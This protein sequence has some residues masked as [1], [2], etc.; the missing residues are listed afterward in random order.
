MNH[1]L[2]QNHIPDLKRVELPE[3]ITTEQVRFALNTLQGHGPQHAYRL[4]IGDARAA[5]H[6]PRQLSRK[7]DKAKNNAIVQRYMRALVAELERVAVANALDLK[8]FLS[9]VV[10]TP[11]GAI[12]ENHVLCQKK[13]T[14]TTTSKAG[15]ETTRQLVEMPSKKD[16]AALLIR[17]QGLD[18]PIRVDHNHR[19]GVMV[20]PMA[21]NVGDWERIA[22]ASQLKLMEDAIEI[23]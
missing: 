6:T 22:A 21:A 15:V 14:I 4:A 16:C 7:A 12:D 19:G 3:G 1:A 20:V 18:A 2:I 9:A 11:V 17:M 13:T 5:D 8:M 23:G 10:Y